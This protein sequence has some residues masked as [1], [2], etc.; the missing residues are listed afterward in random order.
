MSYF[1][2]QLKIQAKEN[3]PFLQWMHT[4]I[5]SI[6]KA[7]IHENKLKTSRKDLDLAKDIKE[8][9]QLEVW[10]KTTHTPG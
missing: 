8:E 5:T 1:F 6:Y 4:K 7:T 3:V 10:E 9:P 2:K